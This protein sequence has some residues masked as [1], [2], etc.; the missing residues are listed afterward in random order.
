MVAHYLGVVGVAGSNPVVPIF[1]KSVS[2]LNLR[3]A[4]AYLSL[5]LIL[6]QELSKILCSDFSKS[7]LQNY[8]L[9]TRLDFL[10]IS[11]KI[12]SL[13]TELVMLALL[14]NNLSIVPI[15]SKS[16]LQN[17]ILSTRLDFLRIS[18]KIKSLHTELVMLALLANNLSIVPFFSKSPL[19]ITLFNSRSFLRGFYAFTSSP[20]DFLICSFLSPKLESA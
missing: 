7:S 11:S 13:H 14:A 1:S 3:L 18:S 15:F 4:Y 20:T 16:S 8:I 9:S 2:R 17:Y 6:R 5:W 10:R 12:K 19:R